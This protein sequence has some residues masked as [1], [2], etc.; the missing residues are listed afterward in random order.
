LAE[1]IAERLI[2]S[3]S[4]RGQAV[5]HTL[6]QVAGGSATVYGDK[7]GVLGNS[8]VNSSIGSQWKN[9]ISEVDSKAVD[10]EPTS[11]VNVKLNA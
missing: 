6:D 1:S 3:R 4:S 8:E 9:N 10:V 11:N 7:T 5:L 2:V